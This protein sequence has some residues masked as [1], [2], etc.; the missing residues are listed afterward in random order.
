M[1]R[2][3][4]PIVLSAQTIAAMPEEGFSEAATRGDVT[5]KT[6]LSS[7]RTLSDTL[8]S[9]LARCAPR[10]GHLKCHRHT[11]PEVYHVVQGRGIVTVDGEEKEVG[12]GSVVFI[13]G[14]AEHGI[15]NEDDEDDLVWLYVFAVDT[16][17]EVV[18]RFGEGGTKAKL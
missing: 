2:P 15:R 18:Y 7:S 11:H 17:E 9:G 5:W 10:G 4:R 8:T 13:P 12:R 1:A 6:L 16:F 3:A 14:N